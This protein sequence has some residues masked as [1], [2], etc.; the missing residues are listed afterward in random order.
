MHDDSGN[1]G[2]GKRDR[3]GS[4]DSEIVRKGTGV[5]GNGSRTGGFGVG[6]GADTGVDGTSGRTP[7]GVSLQYQGLADAMD[8]FLRGERFMRVRE[9]GRLEGPAESE[10]VVRRHRMMGPEK[11]PED[12]PEVELEASCD[13]EMT[14]Q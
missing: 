14:L 5:V 4:E 2:D 11:E 6:A 9:M 7:G 3:G 1:S 8:L 12:V 10:M 13:V